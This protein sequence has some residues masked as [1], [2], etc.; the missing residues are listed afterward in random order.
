V[1]S[2][3]GNSKIAHKA[4]KANKAN[5]A[6]TIFCIDK[7]KI[8]RFYLRTKKAKNVRRVIFS[9]RGTPKPLLWCGSFCPAC[10]GIFIAQTNAHM[11]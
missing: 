4:S 11:Q 8:D 7:N 3:A 1:V 6:N 5:K 9:F 2:N 10:Q